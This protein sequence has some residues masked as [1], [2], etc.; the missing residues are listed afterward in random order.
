MS[1]RPKVGDRSREV[2]VQDS[3]DLLG[4]RRCA[5]LSPQN[6]TRTT[7]TKPSANKRVGPA[8]GSM[9]LLGICGPHLGRRGSFV[10]KPPN[11]GGLWEGRDDDTVRKASLAAPVIA[12]NRDA[13]LPGRSVVA[14]PQRH[15]VDCLFTASTSNALLESCSISACVSK[16]FVKRP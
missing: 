13:R 3:F 16:R 14:F 5:V 4:S 10:F 6:S 7:P 11:R 1:P 12:A 8:P 2:E 9:R 15:H